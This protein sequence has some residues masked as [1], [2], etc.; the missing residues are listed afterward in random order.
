MS[1]STKVWQMVTTDS[2][3][4]VGASVWVSA[5]AAQ[6]HLATYAA[7]LAESDGEDAATAVVTWEGNSEQGWSGY[8][9]YSDEHFALEQVEVNR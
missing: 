9:E 4:F 5:E 3:G 2:E 1:E 6:Q 8:F 7:E